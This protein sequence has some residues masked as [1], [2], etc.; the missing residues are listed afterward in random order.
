[1][2]VLNSTSKHAFIF[3][4]IYCSSCLQNWNFAN[5]LDNNLKTIIICSDGYW[6]VKQ[7]PSVF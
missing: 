7:F 1:M 5:G 4:L 3:L 2:H 6:P